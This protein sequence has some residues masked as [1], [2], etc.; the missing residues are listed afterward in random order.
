[1]LN[2]RFSTISVI[3]LVTMNMEVFFA[4]QYQLLYVLI[5]YHNLPNVLKYFLIFQINYF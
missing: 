4:R 1:M 3:T 5:N 2:I